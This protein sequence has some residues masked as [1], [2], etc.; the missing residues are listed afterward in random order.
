MA[1]V[2]I[3]PEEGE[4]LKRLYGELAETYSQTAAALRTDPPDHVLKASALTRLAEE[5]AKAAAIIRRIQEIR[6]L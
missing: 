1:K 5:D 3:T 2:S 6:G 4:E